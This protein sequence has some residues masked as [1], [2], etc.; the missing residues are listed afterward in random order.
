MKKRVVGLLLVACM[1]VG[2]LVACGQSEQKENTP[3]DSK[4]EESKKEESSAA[5]EESKAEEVDYDPFGKYEEE[6][7]LTIAADDGMMK[8]DSTQDGYGSIDDNVW[9]RLYKERLGINLEYIWTA[10]TDQYSTKWN[11]SI[12][13]GD[14]PDVAV[15]SAGVYR[16]LVEGGLV[17]DMTEAF[18][19]YASDVYKSSV[20]YDGGTCLAAVSQGDRIIG[21]PHPSSSPSPWDGMWI[22]KDWLDELGLE[23]PETVED[24][25]NVARAFVENDMGGENTIGLGANMNLSVAW[26]AQ[27]SAFLAGFGAYNEIWVDDAN[28]D[29]IWG[30]VQ[31]EMKEALQTLQDMYKEGLIPEDFAA[32]KEDIA[33]AP[34]SAG[35]CGIL[36]APGWFNAYNAEINE[37][38]DWIMI[39]PVVANEGDAFRARANAAPAYYLFVSKDCEY[40]E[41]VVKMVNLQLEIAHRD[42]AGEE[43]VKGV[44]GTYRYEANGEETSIDAQYYK[45]APFLK[46]PSLAN[47]ANVALVAAAKGDRTQADAMGFGETVD[48]MMTVK[49]GTCDPKDMGAAFTWA[50]YGIDGYVDR[51]LQWQ[52]NNQMM[53]NKF[54]SAYSE[55]ADRNLRNITDVLYG[56]YMKI[57]MGADISNF[58]KAVETWYSTGGQQITDEVNEWY[59]TTK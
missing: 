34:A 45:L 7:T 23:I 55:F 42:N 4:V 16:Q 8:F 41:A 27:L 43:G 29:L 30:S 33:Y 21:L 3:A 26:P 51:T 14:I 1:T 54:L 49:D 35:Q 48:Q 50:Y 19:L 6:I 52:A 31:P 46:D 25:I 32:T 28:G 22:R 38:G 11:V 2:S 53:T 57:I 24:L 12:A 36:Y 37:V 13:S 39:E 56:E 9:T 59:A 17:A 5:G 10:P 18:E 20:A 44:Y 47:A 58:D 15:V 40:P